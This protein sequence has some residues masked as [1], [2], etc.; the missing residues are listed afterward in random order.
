MNRL[1]RFVVAGLALA[2]LAPA[3]ANPLEVSIGL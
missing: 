1:L 3:S 2:V